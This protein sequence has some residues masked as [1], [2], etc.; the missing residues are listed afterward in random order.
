LVIKLIA[1]I[2]IEF[3]IKD[4]ID[5]GRSVSSLDLLLEIDSDDQ[6]RTKL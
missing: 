2:Q 5:T 3:D 6:V 1:S 4:T